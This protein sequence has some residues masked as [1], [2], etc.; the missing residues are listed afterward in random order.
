MM[1]NFDEIVDRS[2]TNSLK[3]DISEG[4]LPMWVADMDFRT[5]PEIINAVTERAQQGIFGYNIIPYEWSDAICGWW[6]DRH[7]L[8]IRPEWLVFC[9]GVV[10]AISSVIRRLT[11]VGEKVIVT[12]PVYNIFFNSIYNNGRRIV[13]NPLKYENGEYSFD[14]EDLEKKLA[15][16]EATML[17]L[18]NPQNPSGKI[19]SREVLERIAEL[20]YRNHVIVVSDEI[21]CDITDPGCEYVPFASVSELCGQISVT[22][23]SPSKAFNIAGMQSAAVIVPDEGLR[24]KVIRGLNTD[25]LAEPNTFAITAAVAAY[26]KGGAWLDELRSYIY[27]SKCTAEKF[28]A[29]KLPMIRLVRSE[30]TYL[31]WAD[32]SEILKDGSDSRELCGFIREKTGLFIS[33]GKAYGGNGADFVRINI[34]CPRSVMLEGLERFAKGV[35]MWTERS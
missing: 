4:E 9:S 7:G 10:P 8:D 31:L 1:Y 16:P 35:E 6:H 30:A 3:W 13:E 27:D 22:C 20:C 17:L 32:C 19:W 24:N 28:F 29:E 21:H 11:A 12:T 18:C 26:T 14:L 25:E 15:D 34:A 5:A 2:G 23:I 33:N